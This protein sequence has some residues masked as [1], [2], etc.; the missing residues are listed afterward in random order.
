MSSQ[1][2]VDAIRSVFADN[3]Y[4]GDDRITLFNAE[5]RDYDET[6]KLLRGRSWQVMP[7]A[8]FIQGDTPIPDLT[9]EA[10][11]YYMPALLLAAI[12]DQFY[13]NTDV[14]SSITFFLSPQGARCTEGEFP[15]DD[16]DN[17]NRRLSLF[18]EPER[19]VIVRVL[20]ELRSRDWID[21]DY[22]RTTVEAVRRGRFE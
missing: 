13:L 14:A 3:A 4:P 5:G 6:F 15:Y 19:D 2:L 8:Q 21:E 10:F 22:A 12:D 7:V 16:V 17:Y 18:T 9:P 20:Q 1:S 11:R